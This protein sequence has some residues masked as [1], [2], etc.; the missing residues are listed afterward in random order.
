MPQYPLILLS[1]KHSWNFFVD[2]EG[3]CTKDLSTAFQAVRS[4]LIVT[5]VERLWPWHAVIIPLMIIVCQCSCKE[6]VNRS[7]W[8]FPECLYSTNMTD[9]KTKNKTKNKIKNNV[10]LPSYWEENPL[11]WFPFFFRKTKT[12]TST[13]N[14][15]VCSYLFNTRTQ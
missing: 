8:D 14:T 1:V 7:A 10:F 9:L 15:T 3:R 13:T 11:T 2:M 5:Y 4:L 6:S 12:I